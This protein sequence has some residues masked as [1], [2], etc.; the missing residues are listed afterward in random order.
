MTPEEAK[1]FYFQYNGFSFH[2]GR[3]EPE[4]YRSF[5]RLHLGEDIF[6]QWDEELLEG[7][8]RNLRTETTRFW[9]VHDDILQVIRRRHCDTEYWLETLLDAMSKLE[10]PD[11]R[12]AVLIIE[13]M[14]GRNAEMN[15]G[16]VYTFCRY[17]DL[18]ERMNEVMEHLID[19]CTAEYDAGDR[20]KKAVQRYRHS[21]IRW[22]TGTEKGR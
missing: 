16:G 2:M 7:L 10:H 21:Y 17:S 13:N 12:N 20:F 19:R 4:K 9:A 18:A 15:D 1:K 6:R 3:E 11:E 14:A 5:Q 8:F 22:R